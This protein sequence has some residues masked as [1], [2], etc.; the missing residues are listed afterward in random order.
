MVKQR[1]TS[2]HRGHA[3]AG[4]PAEETRRVFGGSTTPTK[5]A[6]S[7]AGKRPERRPGHGERASKARPTQGEV[8]ALLESARA[9]LKHRAF[10]DAARVIFDQCKALIGATAGYVALLSSEGTENEV[11]FLDSG[12]LSC[13]VD[14]SLPMPIRGLR[15]QVYQTGQAAYENDFD[16]SKWASLLPEGHATLNNVLFAP[17]TIDGAVVGL[18][19]IANKPGGFT[20]SDA[21]LATAF[22]E[23]AAVAL[24]NSRT[25]DALQSSE[26]RFH[27]LVE[28]ASDAIVCAD[29]SGEIVLW[30]RGAEAMF[31]CPAAEA[32]G[33]PVTLIMPDRF[34]NGHRRGMKRFLATG[35]P[36]IM[37]RAIEM[38]ARRSDSSEF[39][40]ELSLTAWKTKQ[41]TFFAGIIRDVSERK[42]AEENLRSS[43]AWFRSIFNESPIGIEV[44]DAEGRLLDANQAC[45]GIFGV[46][47]VE[48]VRGFKLFENP[49]LSNEAK[50]ALRRGERV[51]YE[52]PFDFEKVRAANLYPTSRS[53][54]IY[55]YIVLTPL[56]L[57]GKG[58]V[59]GYLVQLMDVT[60][61]RA[62]QE[63]LE[64]MRSEFLGEVS[65]ELKTPLTAIK[66]STAM[67]LTSKAPPAPAEA[68]E[69]FEVIDEQAER[70]RELIGNLLDMTRIE[71]GS[72]SVNPQPVRLSQVIEE[73]VTTFARTAGDHPVNVAIPPSLPP[74]I[75][76][77]R[78]IGQVVANLLANAAKAS[79]PGVPIAISA[80]LGDGEVTLRVRDQGRGIAF[81]KLPLLFKKFAQVHESG[82]RGTGLGLVICKGIVES[83]G[84]RIWAESPGEGEGATFSFTL[85]IAVEGRA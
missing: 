62:I 12:G 4:T 15:A 30:N 14:P 33:Q 7:R 55:L 73:A 52:T 9:V 35:K 32:I 69:L 66:G 72:L 65:H 46:S 80:E 42:Q 16:S 60:H 5:P 19:G 37:G 63:E 51:S 39:P 18:L 67:A 68:R 8:E 1:A 74:V 22:G 56:G 77:R 70:M 61:E 13:S 24:S 20:R 76:D 59:R 34:H 81:D 38:F 40:V 48:D 50:A 41:E 64:R 29:S 10:P 23:L 43:E 82:G 11:L 58:R 31:G 25:L 49:N 47:S 17:L 79:P 75:A 27:S 28:T 2:G 54:V 57:K 21:R 85:P 6:L 78:R 44:Y 71:A 3:S 26:H 83:H 84:G 45:L 53:G 36:R